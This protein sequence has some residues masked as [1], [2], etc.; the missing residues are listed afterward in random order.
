MASRGTLGTG[1]IA[2]SYRRNMSKISDLENHIPIAHMLRNL[3]HSKASLLVDVTVDNV[4]CFSFFSFFISRWARTTLL[5][6]QNARAEGLQMT[7]T[8]SL[9]WRMN[10]KNKTSDYI[11]DYTVTRLTRNHCVTNYC[12]NSTTILCFASN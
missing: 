3:F 9:G 11:L 7:S 6:A 8:E 10:E 4:Q 5:C 12:S 2:S 1:N